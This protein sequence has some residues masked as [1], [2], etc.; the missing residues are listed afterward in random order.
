MQIYNKLATD[1]K[2]KPEVEAEVVFARDTRVSGPSLVKALE[3]GLKATG[4]QY[5]DFGIFTTPQ[6]HYVTRCLNTKGTTYSFGEPTEEG[7]YKKMA[8]AFKVVM[9]YKKTR[10]FVTV[11]CANGVGGPKLRELVKHLEP[12]SKGGVDIN[13]IND[14]VAKTEALN[15][16]V[17]SAQHFVAASYSYNL[18]P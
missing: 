8:D 18:H 12:A 9:K 13:I 16:D 4:A 7:Y 10:A 14:D 15:L 3:D 6:L 1:L 2:L 11:D 17:S 5:Q